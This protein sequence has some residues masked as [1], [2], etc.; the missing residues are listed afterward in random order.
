[1]GRPC[2]NVEYLKW[3][4]VHEELNTLLYVLKKLSPVIHGMVVQSQE[5]TEEIAHELDQPLLQCEGAIVV[6][7]EVPKPAVHFLVVSV[8]DNKALVLHPVGWG[9][10]IDNDLLVDVVADRFFSRGAYVTR[11]SVEKFYQQVV[12][13]PDPDWRPAIP[14]AKIQRVLVARLELA[15]RFEGPKGGVDTVNVLGTGK[16][17]NRPGSPK[18]SILEIH[19]VDMIDRRGMFEDASDFEIDLLVDEK[20]GQRGAGLLWEL[21]YSAIVVYTL[22]LAL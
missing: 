16:L 14:S 13:G 20:Q 18:S 10:N 11:A 9:L 6:V 1:M 4:P 8:V 22:T 12:E 15:L 3:L 17:G 2:V 5:D 19:N 7:R 21:P